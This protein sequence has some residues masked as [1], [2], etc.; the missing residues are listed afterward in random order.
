M[1]CC[2][3]MTVLENVDSLRVVSPHFGC[4]HHFKTFVDGFFGRLSRQ[5]LDAAETTCLTQPEDLVNLH[6]SSYER[7]VAIDPSIAA[8]R[9][10]L[11]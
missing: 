5:R 10:V 11:F 1:L 9:Y 6:T 4:E 8:E 7:R 3:G 2:P